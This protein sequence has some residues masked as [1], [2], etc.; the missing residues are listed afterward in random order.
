MITIN[1][2]INTSR[3]IYASLLFF[4]PAS[5]AGVNFEISQVISIQSQLLL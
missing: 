5:L 4:A 2:L 1:T 3:S